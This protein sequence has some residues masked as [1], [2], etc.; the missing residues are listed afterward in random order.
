[1]PGGWAVDGVRGE[2][3]GE[4]GGLGVASGGQREMGITVSA[5][6]LVRNFS[7]ASYGQEYRQIATGITIGLVIAF[8]WQATVMLAEHAFVPV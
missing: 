4:T 3:D 2:A 6:G 5:G 8:G 7:E 1:M